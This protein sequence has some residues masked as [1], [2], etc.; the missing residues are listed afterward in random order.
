MILI[1]NHMFALWKIIVFING[2]FSRLPDTCISVCNIEQLG[3]GPGNEAANFT[4]VFELIITI[5]Y[6]M[7]ACRIFGGEVP[8]HS[9][10]NYI[11]VPL[12]FTTYYFQCH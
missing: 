12:T 4:S 10:I 1:L 6:N 2:Q 7:H 9:E 11:H 5:Y 8:K 3:I